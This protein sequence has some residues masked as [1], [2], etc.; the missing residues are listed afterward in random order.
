MSSF[1]W[2]TVFPLRELATRGPYAVLHCGR[3]C[4]QAIVGESLATR[5]L[6]AAMNL[7]VP[8]AVNGL[9][10][11][12]RAQRQQLAWR[13]ET[14]EALD[15]DKSVEIVRDRPRAPPLDTRVCVR[16]EG[17]I[18][19][20]LQPFTFSFSGRVRPVQRGISR[21]MVSCTCCARTLRRRPHPRSLQSPRTRYLTA[22]SRSF[23]RRPLDGRS[24]LSGGNR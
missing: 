4:T 22:G 1:L 10:V 8:P 18:R 23:R 12:E 19:K 16:G 20:L 17:V 3:E 11:P 15:G 7:K 21:A 13:G 9:F 2:G 14:L 24:A 6:D 5:V